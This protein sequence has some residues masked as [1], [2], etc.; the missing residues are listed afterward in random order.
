MFLRLRSKLALLREKG[1][2]SDSATVETPGEI[3]HRD[4]PLCGTASIKLS[5]ICMPVRSMD[6]EVI[7]VDAA[8]A[9]E[10]A[11]NTRALYERTAMHVARFEVVRQAVRRYHALRCHSCPLQHF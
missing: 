9:R 10:G 3:G 1:Y 6:Q 11:D 2:I 7:R 4:A 5:K 8:L